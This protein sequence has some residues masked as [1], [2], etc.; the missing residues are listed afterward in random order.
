MND[1]GEVTTADVFIADDDLIV[2]QS[3]DGI[4]ADRKLMCV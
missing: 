2:R 3:T 4:H 1:N